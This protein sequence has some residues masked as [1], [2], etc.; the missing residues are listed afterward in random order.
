LCFTLLYNE[1]YCIPHIIAAIINL[2]YFVHQYPCCKNIIP[3]T[4][5]PKII[6]NLHFSMD[7]LKLQFYWICRLWTWKVLKRQFDTTS[8]IIIYWRYHFW[9]KSILQGIGACN[10]S[11]MITTEI[12]N[13]IHI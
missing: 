8:I 11:K 7:A 3:T 1:S 2:L 6:S 4:A 9:Q 13:K 5:K 12:S 10:V